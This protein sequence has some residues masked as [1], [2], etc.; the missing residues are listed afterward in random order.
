MAAGD[1]V[2]AD[3]AENPE[4]RELG[5]RQKR[6]ERWSTGTLTGADGAARWGDA[7]STVGTA[8]SAARSEKPDMMLQ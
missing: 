2:M 8:N 7:E 6:I 3:T 1:V 4:R 5:P